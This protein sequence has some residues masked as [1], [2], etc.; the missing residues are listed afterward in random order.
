MKRHMNWTGRKRIG[1]EHIEIRLFDATKTEPRRFEAQ[2]PGLAVLGLDDGARIVVE[3]YVKASSMRFEFGTIRD[4]EAPA[5]TGLTDID[6]AGAVMFRVRIVDTVIVPGRVLANAERIQARDEGESSNDRKCLLPLKEADLGEAVWEL[7]L[8][9]GQGPYLVINKRIPQIAV[10]MKT[11]P[12][13]QGA[14]F[15]IALE[16]IVTAIVCDT[17]FTDELP[18]VE[19]WTSWIEELV[20]MRV[21][22]GDDDEENIQFVTD[23]VGTFVRRNRFATLTKPPEMDLEAAYD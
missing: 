23:V 9:R 16:K 15:P 8:T 19:Q 21:P 6:A 12:L 5:N 4:Q 3:P 22:D 2:F 11:D 1:L 14:V 17:E 18:W 13:L 10:K 20:G 7:E